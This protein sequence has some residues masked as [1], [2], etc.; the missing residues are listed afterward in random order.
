MPLLVENRL[1]AD[2]LA[3]YRFSVDYDHIVST[4]LYE[5]QFFDKTDKKDSLDTIDR[6]LLNRLTTNPNLH[7]NRDF[8]WFVQN[9]N[10]KGKSSNVGYF[11][12]HTCHKFKFFPAIRN[13]HG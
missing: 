2:P 3:L 1:E 4:Y 12:L 10:S 11:L 7:N 9:K 6:S 8:K 5:E 13:N